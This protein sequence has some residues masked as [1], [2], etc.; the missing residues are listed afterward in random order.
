M[1]I[2]MHHLHMNNY[3]QC[4]WPRSMYVSTQLIPA[5]SATLC[6]NTLTES[7]VLLP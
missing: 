5:V 4:M 1:G 7:A 6:R 3:T 2:S